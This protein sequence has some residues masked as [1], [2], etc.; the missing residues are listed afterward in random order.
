MQ[1]TTQLDLSITFRLKLPRMHPRSGR[2]M[3]VSPWNPFE[4]SR[5]GTLYSVNIAMWSCFA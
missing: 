2:P 1:D 5:Q 4:Q 3:M